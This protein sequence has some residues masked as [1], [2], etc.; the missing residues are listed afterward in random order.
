VF[1]DTSANRMRNHKKYL[2]VDIADFE[3]SLFNILRDIS[4]KIFIDY[5]LLTPNPELNF[6]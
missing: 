6:R 5:L 4:S 1:T 2:L 3:W